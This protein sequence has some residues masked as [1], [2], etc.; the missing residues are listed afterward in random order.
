[1]CINVYQHQWLYG[2]KYYHGELTHYHS[3]VLLNHNKHCYIKII[4]IFF[5]YICFVSGY[6][7]NEKLKT[8][9]GENYELIQ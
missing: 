7:A 4:F 3:A 9:H 8:H 1:M 6:T 2:M 5:F